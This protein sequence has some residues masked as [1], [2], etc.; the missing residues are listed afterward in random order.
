TLSPGLKP[1]P[2]DIDK[3][4][5][6]SSGPLMVVTWVSK[7]CPDGDPSTDGA[8]PGVQRAIGYAER[9]NRVIPFSCTWVARSTNGGNTWSAPL[10]LS[11]GVRD[12]IQDA[13]GGSFNSD[14]R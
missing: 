6:K 10:Q 9:D 12:A 7:Y 8:Q 2:G 1:Y 4:N 13:S 3:P 5:V 14:T 11:S